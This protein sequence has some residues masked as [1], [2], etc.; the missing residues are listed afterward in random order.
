MRMRCYADALSKQTSMIAGEGFSTSRF[1]D[2]PAEIHKEIAKTIDPRLG[3]DP[4]SQ[5]NSDP[6]A[7]SQAYYHSGPDRTLAR[8]TRVCKR[9][10]RVYGPFS[11]WRTL[12]IEANDHLS[13]KPNFKLPPSV[14]RVLDYP[15]TGIH[16]RQLLIRYKGYDKK[17]LDE[18]FGLDSWNNFNKFLAKT[19]RLDTVRCIGTS[20]NEDGS[21]RL[22][23]EFFK[24]LSSLASLRYIYLGEFDIR[25]KD[26]PAFPPLDQ[27]RILRYSPTQM[28]LSI[29]GQLL[30]SSMPNIHT[31]YITGGLSG[32]DPEGDALI[33]VDVLNAILVRLPLSPLAFQHSLRVLSVLHLFFSAPF[34]SQTTPWWPR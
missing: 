16:A 25:K 26:F 22:P 6:I 2:L 27:V 1:V 7:P 11:T 20:A 19:P 28:R 5:H 3:S 21:V 4:S 12:Y 17:G 15:E 13:S 31:L 23:Y 14:T 34:F 10:Q 29:L 32:P 9:L 33:V 30:R 8:L 18:A 24:S